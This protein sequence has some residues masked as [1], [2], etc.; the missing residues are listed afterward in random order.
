MLQQIGRP[1]TLLSVLEYTYDV[2]WLAETAMRRVDKA[3]VLAPLVEELEEGLRKAFLRQGELFLEQ[4]FS[5]T[6]LWWPEKELREAVIPPSVV[7]SPDDWAEWDKQSI[8]LLE[9]PIHKIMPKSLEGGKF[10]A[11]AD[12]DWTAG[13]EVGFDKNML[14]AM[15]INIAQRVSGVQETTKKYIRTQIDQGVKEGW[16]Y[17]Q[18]AKAISTRFEEFAVGRPQEH[19]RSR[20]HL[21][22]VNETAELH[23]GAREATAN[24]L[25][26]VGLLVERRWVTVGDGKVS[27]GC[28]A[29]AAQDW[30]ANK[31][32]F[33]SG[34][35]RPPRF[36]GCRCDLHIQRKKDKPEPKPKVKKPPK[37]GAAKKAKAKALKPEKAPRMGPTGELPPLG[38][39][40]EVPDWIK[41]IY[42]EYGEEAA[43]AAWYGS[44]NYGDFDSFITT[45]QADALSK[46]QTSSYAGMN[47][48]LRAGYRVHYDEEGWWDV[49]ERDPTEI[50]DDIVHLDDAIAT[51]L[52]KEETT[53]YRGMNLKRLGI[54]SANDLEDAIGLIIEDNGFGSSSL[55]QSVGEMFAAGAEEKHGPGMGVVCEIRLP[56]GQAAGWVA[57]TGSD[58]YAFES[59]LLLPR[60]MRYEV[61]EVIRDVDI[62]ALMHHI[63]DAGVYDVDQFNHIVLQV[64]SG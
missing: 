21:V 35:R 50:I 9:E 1:S 22:A 38:T 6:K 11:V 13:F 63:E 10:S 56:E 62:T 17:D 8:L 19:I 15:E 20:A 53:T 44:E 48:G 59:E 12:L 33:Q 43:K 14:W 2:A 41:R 57:Q 5:K 30:I 39:A 28:R 31:L 52:L 51:N 46:Y 26:E 25:V 37:P 58:S 61:T 60:G 47:E 49:V 36:P 42:E 32:S 3:K 34:H 54:T 16:S 18:M 64:V 7:G 45:E 4:V 40:E 55:S 23:M 24:A 29:N 27:D